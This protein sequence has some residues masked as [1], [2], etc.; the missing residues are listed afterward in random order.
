MK[1]KRTRRV[2]DIDRT[3]TPRIVGIGTDLPAAFVIDTNYI[4]E[5]VLVE[6][7]IIK[8]AVFIFARAVLYAGRRTV[9]VIDEI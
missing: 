9:L 1:L 6:E 4:A 3:L 7:V 8:F 5:Y 2:Y